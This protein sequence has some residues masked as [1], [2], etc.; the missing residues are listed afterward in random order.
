MSADI[1]VAVL[2]L[3]TFIVDIVVWALVD[4]SLYIPGTIILIAV[5][6]CWF[7]RRKP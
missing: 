3:L 6:S 2:E 5:L 1:V 4:A 7:A